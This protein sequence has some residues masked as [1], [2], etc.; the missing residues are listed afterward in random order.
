MEDVIDKIQLL[1]LIRK[2]PK[3]YFHWL[4]SELI[5]ELISFNWSLKRFMIGSGAN[6][7]VIINQAGEVY[8]FG[9]KIKGQ[10]GRSNGNYYKPG[11][12]NLKEKIISVS[13][14][15]EH[16]ILLS[17][18]GRVYSFGDNGYGQL[19]RLGN[20]GIPLPIKS[21]Y[22]SKI[23]SVHCG[24]FHTVV[25]S[26]KGKAYSFG[27]GGSNQLGRTGDNTIPQEINLFGNKKCIFVSC[28][29]EHTLLMSTNYQICCFGNVNN[30][31]SIK[32]TQLDERIVYACGTNHLILLTKSGRVYSFGN[33]EDGQLGRVSSEQDNAPYI[34][35]SM[36]DKKIIF[37]SCGLYHTILMSQEGKVYSF[38]KN[39][40]GQLGRTIRD[41][42][43]NQIKSLE[44]KNIVFGTCGNKNTF[45]L[46]GNSGEV[47]CFGDNTNGQLGLGDTLDREVP[48]L[49]SMTSRDG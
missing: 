12:I 13:C 23:I 45:L 26:D 36:K 29:F 9:E 43:C 28:G 22:H 48:V 47:Y 46:D 10:L 2:D 1:E 7:T 4:P 38:G 27:H 41:L 25:L 11:K 37:A 33:N 24:S 20:Y 14:G 19:G 8:S 44:N 17:D 5:K 3:F 32:K 15:F 18:K 31:A 40:G 49:L 35:E 42:K 21:L 39:T 6:H 34:I 30:L 16:T